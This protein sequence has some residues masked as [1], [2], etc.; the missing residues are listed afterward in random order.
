MNGC[1]IVYLYIL[2]NRIVI[3]YLYVISTLLTMGGATFTTCFFR[4]A[5]LPLYFT[6][7]S[8]CL[9]THTYA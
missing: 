8:E 7:S 6:N 3:V 9:H 4:V 5:L 1:L 2:S